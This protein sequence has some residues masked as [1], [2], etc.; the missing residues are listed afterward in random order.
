[1]RRLR[2]NGSDA[3]QHAPCST[4]RV[5]TA[6][7]ELQVIL[8]L[9]S[10]VRGENRITLTRKALTGM[11]AY[12]RLWGGPLRMVL[13]EGHGPTQN[14][15]EEEIDTSELPFA[16]DVLDLRSPALRERVQG[17]SVVMGS[18]QARD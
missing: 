12:H 1:M 14:L 8:Q 18:P 7:G 11:E 2:L 4:R 15:D 17:A 6:T 5:T 13:P 3:A 9:P 16:I 10:E